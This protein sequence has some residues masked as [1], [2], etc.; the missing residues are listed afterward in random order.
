MGDFAA[1]PLSLLVIATRR[2]VLE[3]Y[4]QFVALKEYELRRP[5]RDAAGEAA[6]RKLRWISHP[7]QLWPA[8]GVIT[9]FYANPYIGGSEILLGDRDGVLVG[10]ALERYRRVHGHY[11]QNLA[12]LTPTWLAEIPADRITGNPV[13]YL[14]K[15]GKPLVYSVGADR[16]DNGGTPGIGM[17]GPDPT[18]A[19]LWPPMRIMIPGDWILYPH[20]R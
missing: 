18:V 13:K 10:I 6:R 17:Y 3:K 20:A 14:L 11:P 9:T 15:A 1:A 4:D 2:Q 12:E 5:A 7:D 19:A 8:F 16:V